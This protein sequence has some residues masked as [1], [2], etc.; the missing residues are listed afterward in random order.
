LVLNRPFIEMETEGCLLFYPKRGEPKEI[1]VPEKE[2]Y[3]CEVE[4]IHAAILDGRTQYLSLQETRD[5]VRTVLGLYE[6]A[7]TNQP[8]RLDD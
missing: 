4:D 2:L 3:L 5:H 7:N 1:P 6:S 8:V